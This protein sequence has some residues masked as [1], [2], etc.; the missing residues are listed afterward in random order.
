MSFCTIARDQNN[1]IQ[2]VYAE[3]KKPSIL[4]HSLVDLVKDKEKALNNYLKIFTTT[5]RKEFGDWKNDT[6]LAPKLDNNGEPLMEHLN[7]IQTIPAQ[8][9]NNPIGNPNLTYQELNESDF[10]PSGS[11][12]STEAIDYFTKQA[13]GVT[14]DE[15]D[16]N[17]TFYTDGT[18]R[19]KR[20]TE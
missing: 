7:S 5:F 14:L 8:P 1:V 2:E 20:L 16:P 4:W 10:E 3:N 6:S 17:D 11:L 12:G 19:Y 18:N 9:A 13:Q 15:N